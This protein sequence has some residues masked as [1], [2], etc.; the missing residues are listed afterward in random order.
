MTSKDSYFTAPKPIKIGVLMDVPERHYKYAFPIYDYLVDRYVA[1]GRLHRGIELVKKIITGPPSGYID[2][3]MRGYHEL[4]DEGVL[5]V[6]GPNHSDNN[7]A[8]TRHAEQRK[9]PIMTLGAIHSHVSPHVFNIGWGTV[10]EDGY[11]VASWL[12]QQGYSRV[13]F[14]YDNAAHCKLYAHWFRIAARRL[15][16]KIVAD[17]CVS[18]VNDDNAR[19]QMVV[20]LN[21]QQESQPDAIAFFGTGASQINWGKLVHASGWDIPRIMNGAFFQANYAY[22]HEFFDGWVGTALWDD[23]NRTLKAE[24]EEFA[25]SCPDLADVAPEIF[26]LYRDGMVSLLEGVCEAP[27][28][29]PV[30]VTQGLE[31]VRMIPAAVG[32]DRQVISFGPYDRIGHKGMDKMVVRRLTAG[33][34]IMEGRFEPL[35]SFGKTHGVQA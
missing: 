24:L 6:I 30:G 2:D 14:G 26:A 34:L 27:I 31:M 35:S 21:E 20:L 19:A 11:Y 28:L 1:G 13:A 23:D 3:V 12:Q 22:T 16:L 7:I 32:G 29:T 33:K 17:T 25:E 5:A 10:P 8:I 15:G 9:V 18:E 4:C